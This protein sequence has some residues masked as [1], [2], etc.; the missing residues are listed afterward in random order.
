MSE[1]FSLSIYGLDVDAFLC[2]VLNITGKWRREHV[3][4]V[5]HNR[6]MGIIYFQFVFDFSKLSVWK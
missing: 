4:I 5:M 1:E 3:K 2:I 6:L